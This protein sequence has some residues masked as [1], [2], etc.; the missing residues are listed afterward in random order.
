[1]SERV[2][3]L[4]LSPDRSNPTALGVAAPVR[5]DD[6]H[7]LLF[8]VLCRCGAAEEGAGLSSSLKVNDRVITTGGIY[9]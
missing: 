8:L 3:P 2:L 7:L 1:M 4:V 5:A 6:R 9:G